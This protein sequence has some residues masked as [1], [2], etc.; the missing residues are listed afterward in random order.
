MLKSKTLVDFE[1]AITFGTIEMLLSKLRN[2][3]EFQE[4]KKPARKRLYGIF[5][6]S[7]DNIYKY[8]AKKPG[9]PGKLEPTPK[10]SVVKKGE[11]YFVRA[12]NMVRSDDVGDLSFKMDRVNQLD[13]EALKSLYEEVINKEPGINDTGAGLG[14]ITMALRTDKKI[15]YSFAVV[16]NDY[17][18]F[19]YEI[20]LN[21]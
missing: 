3:R 8:A 10:I 18:F 13:N 16:D 21:G 1:G 9:K 14:L 19:E 7:I 20:T 4:L 6:E 5:V 17:S 2:T 12:G 15:L 11:H